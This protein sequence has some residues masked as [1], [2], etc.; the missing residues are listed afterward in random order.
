ML[1]SYVNTYGAIQNDLTG[2]Q[3]LLRQDYHTFNNKYNYRPT[4][5]SGSYKVKLSNYR[6]G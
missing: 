6:F 2:F 1:I 4:L 3:Y 5:R